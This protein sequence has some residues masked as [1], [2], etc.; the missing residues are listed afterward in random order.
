MDSVV[1]VDFVEAG[2]AV[3][4]FEAV[5]AASVVVDIVEAVVVDHL[6]ELALHE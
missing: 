4:D 6:E 5:V 2:L 1:V 3:E